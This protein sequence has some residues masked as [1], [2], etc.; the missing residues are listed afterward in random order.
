[1]GSWGEKHAET[2]FGV[3]F[4]LSNQSGDIMLG[5]SGPVERITFLL[6]AILFYPRVYASGMSDIILCHDSEEL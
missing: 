2:L 6:S 4:W 1:M 5:H 3:F